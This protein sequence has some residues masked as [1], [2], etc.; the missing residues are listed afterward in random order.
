MIKE[1]S[2]IDGR[3]WGSMSKNTNKDYFD[4]E[5]SMKDI[6]DKHN[7]LFMQKTGAFNPTKTN[8]LPTANQV[9]R[10]SSIRLKGKREQI[11]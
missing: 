8:L 4:L 9:K 1:I 2:N 3:S 6:I 7:D 5:E 10:H 11:I